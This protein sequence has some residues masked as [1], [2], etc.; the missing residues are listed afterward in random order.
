MKIEKTDVCGLFKQVYLEGI[1]SAFKLCDIVV[2][3][4]NFYNGTFVTDRKKYLSLSYATN[5]NLKDT[6]FGFPIS[7]NQLF[8]ELVHDSNV[9]TLDISPT[10]KDEVVVTYEKEKISIS[11]KKICDYYKIFLSRELFLS[12]LDAEENSPY[13]DVY[14]IDRLNNTLELM[15]PEVSIFTN[16]SIIDKEREE[17]REKEREEE[18]V[19]CNAVSS[20][21]YNPKEVYNSIIKRVIGQDEAAKALVTSVIG[22]MDYNKFEGLKSNVL[23]IGPPG[24]GKTELVESLSKVLDRPYVLV[25]ASNCSATGYIGES[26]SNCLG[27][28]LKRANGNYEVAKRGIVFI[29]EIDKI[30]EDTLIQQNSVNKGDVQNEL[31]KLLESGKTVISLANGQKRIEFDTS[32]VIFIAAGAFSRL[33]EEK[34]K[35]KKSIGFVSEP[36]DAYNDKDKV[37]TNKDLEQYGLSPELLRRLP[38]KIQLR[39]LNVKDLENIITSSSI[40]VL[41]KYQEAFRLENGV[42]MKYTDKCIHKIAEKAYSLGVGASGIQTIVEELLKEVKFEVIGTKEP[43]N[44]LITEETVDDNKN[45]ILTKKLGAGRHELPI[46]NGENHQ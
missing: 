27:T 26:I 45:Y 15:S 36:D 33:F 8:Y 24:V 11:L 43:R 28:L 18:R 30:A 2:G 34:A 42:D 21:R 20:K 37:I 23:L 6:F 10:R 44:L 17:E 39:S 19:K 38:V 46:R 32:E 4:N 13:Y 22:N 41:T 14:M 40:S 25:N 7:L 5:N 35:K 3:V 16:Y 9:G 1:G 31:L 12:L 29:D